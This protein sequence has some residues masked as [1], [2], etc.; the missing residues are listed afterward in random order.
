MVDMT[1][2]VFGQ[3]IS[4]RRLIF[5]DHD[6]ILVKTS[7][8]ALSMGITRDRRRGPRSQYGIPALENAVQPIQN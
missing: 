3:P 7:M 1:K 6:K 2:I 8:S 5:Q 4:A